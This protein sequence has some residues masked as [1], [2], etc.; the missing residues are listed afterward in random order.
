MRNSLHNYSPENRITF[1]EFVYVFPHA[2]MQ[3]YAS[4]LLADVGK[5]YP[6]NRPNALTSIVF[7]VELLIFTM[8][9]DTFELK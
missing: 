6:S 8:T 9:L 3:S 5:F 1:C 4:S 7:G 2:F